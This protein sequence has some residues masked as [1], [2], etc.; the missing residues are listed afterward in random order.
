MLIS[1]ASVK[2]TL[3]WNNKRSWLFQFDT[4]DLLP[5]MLVN[6]K[7]KGW[8]LPLTFLCASIVSQTADAKVVA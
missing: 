2:L 3:H 4:I 1:N 6:S 8:T 7:T 5:S